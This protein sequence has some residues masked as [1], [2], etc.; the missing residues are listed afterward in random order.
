MASA[1][2]TPVALIIFNRPERTAGVF[3]PCGATRTRVCRC[4]WCP[5]SRVAT[6]AAKCIATRAIVEQVEWPREVSRRLA[7][8]NLGLRRNVAE[9][10]DWVFGR[11]E[12][13]I[14]LADD[15]PPDPS[16][17]P[18][19]EDLLKHYAQDRH[20]GAIGRHQPRSSAHCVA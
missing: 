5:R 13:A 19:C 14:I 6:D 15:C 11:T 9:G 8:Q 18:F 17:F 4:G 10:L 2:T 12:R 1:L 20:V 7:K 3:P 16:F